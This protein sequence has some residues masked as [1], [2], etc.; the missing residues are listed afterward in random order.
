M[1]RNYTK[2]L[3]DQKLLDMHLGS[4]TLVI[5]EYHTNDLKVINK[6]N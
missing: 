4:D 6:K 5:I 1:N 2:K 3:T